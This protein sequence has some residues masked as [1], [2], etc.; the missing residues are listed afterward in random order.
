V[1]ALAQPT[2]TGV[3]NGASYIPDGLPN[4][5]VARG[6]LFVVKGSN[7]G[8]PDLVKAGEFPLQ[9]SLAGTSVRVTVGGN[10]VDA[11]MFYSGAEQ[12]AAILPSTVPAGSGTLTVTFN[13]Q[14]SA[15]APITVVQ[16]A[17]GIFTANSSGT[18]DAIATRESELVT[19]TNA[20]NA[21]EIVVIWG[22]GL[23][24]VT[25][26]ETSA[27]V[28]KD[29]TDVPVEA[30]VAGKRATVLFRGRNNC[31]VAVDMIHVQIPAGVS[32]CVTPVVLKIGNVVSNTAS[33]P[34]ATNGR[35]CTPTSSGELADLYSKGTISTGSIT[36]ARTAV[37]TPTGT[38]TKSDS[39][40]ASFY[41]ITVAPG[42]IGLASLLDV[43]TFGSC[44]V[45]SFSGLSSS[46]P[47][48]AFMF[49]SLD[50]G[51]SIGV[52]GP[53]GN[54]ILAKSSNA[55]NISYFETLDS[56]A[57][58]FSAGQ[59]TIIGP[60]GADVGS[61]NASLTL[62]PPLV[63]TNQAAITAV[64]RADGVTLDWTGGD[65]EGYVQIVGSNF[66]PTGAGSSAAATFIC[67]AKTSDGTFTVPPV[68]LLALPQSVGQA[69][70][71]GSL[72]VTGV[73]GATKF[74]ANGL[75]FGT[76]TSLVSATSSLPY[77]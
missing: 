6:A 52:N 55:G 20:A 68:V 76:V 43:A 48:S 1:S 30:F 49:Q 15:S 59:Y 60:G 61:F 54:K 29:T 42:A 63:W 50:A 74:Q 64:K 69:P 17:L 33:I 57:N 11:I 5:G 37:A 28:Q 14:T 32:G 44:I 46:I 34:V 71:S 51:A 3:T 19:P 22:T 24:P 26:D 45:S 67:T 35:T 21:G 16:N 25:F 2:I 39:G 40:S 38:T 18:G 56:D 66:V 36:L 31:C 53:R 10:S 62:A 23:G 27:A 65:P 58:Y 41:K 9:T 7:L 77:Q 8:P 4:A 73:S 70:I 13:R 47:A 75:D 12:V 72:S